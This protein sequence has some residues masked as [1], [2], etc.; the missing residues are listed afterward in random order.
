MWVREKTLNWRILLHALSGGKKKD[1]PI[2][3]V[4]INGFSFGKIQIEIE[5]KWFL[6]VQS[7]D[8]EI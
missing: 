8:F 6:E 5:E 2:S 7:P 4:F 3:W 1:K